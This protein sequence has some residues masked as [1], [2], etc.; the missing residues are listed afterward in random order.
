[1]TARSNSMPARKLP[2][3]TPET[4]AFWTGGKNGELLIQRCG[5]C[6]L[7]QHP[8]LP[9]C[10]ACRTET[11]AS[12]A[13]SGKGKVKTF[14]IN[15]QPWMP[16]LDEPFVFAAVELDEQA[17]LYIFSNILAAPEAVTSGMRVKVSFEHL[18]DVWLPMFTPD[19]EAGDEA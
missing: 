10:S 3:L 17:E 15:H 18:D 8:P 7:Y 5:T 19:G 14:T 4:E 12:A 1:M 16:G 6:G 9:I 13:V 2:L 11:V